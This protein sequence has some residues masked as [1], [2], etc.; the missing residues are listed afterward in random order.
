M[1]LYVFMTATAH[2]VIGT[3]IAAK[4]TNPLMA[5][6][7]AVLSHIAA[8]IFPHWDTATNIDKKGKKRAIFDSFLDVILGFL[9]SYAI[10][11]FLFPQTNLLYVLM[12]ILVSQSPDWVMAPYYL[13]HIKLP[14]SKWTYLLQ[15][16]FNNSLDK[17]WGII[18]QVAVLILLLII[19]KSS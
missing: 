6:P 5:I 12:L 1:L 19:A 3:I 7:L 9:L 18:T 13:F 17:P 11:F 2:A 4:V 15:K 16:S 14:L 8:D 10:I